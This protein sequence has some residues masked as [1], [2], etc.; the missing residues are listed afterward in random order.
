MVTYIEKE[1]KSILNKHKFID[2]WFWDRYSVNA[3]Q[4]CQFNCTYC[5]A[6]SHKY[7][8]HQEFEEIIVVKKDAAGMLDQRISRARTLLP[9]VV[10]MSGV[11]DP[12]Q[13][14]EEIFGNTRQCLRVLERHHWPVHVITKSPLMLRDKE[15]LEKI[16]NNA[17]A[18]VSFTVTT[19]DPDVAAFLEPRAPS[20]LER[21]EALRQ[22]KEHSNNIQTGILMIPIVP[23]LED[24]E[25]NIES[26]VRKARDAGADY[27]L[28]SPGM[29]MRDNQAIW[30]MKELAR[31]CPDLVRK[32]EQLYNFT[33]SAVSYNGEYTPLK[34]Y[35]SEITK[36]ILPILEKYEMP[37][38]IPR[39][40]PT[41]FRRLNYLVAEKLLEDAFVLQMTGKSWKKVFWA[42]QNIQNLK[43][44][45][46]K[47]EDRSELRSIQSVDEEI[48]AI[49][50]REINNHADGSQKALG[51]FDSTAN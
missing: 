48:E 1:F 6:R 30:F 40:I 24:G 12:Y 45:I 37:F 39:F 23:F 7:H 34:A 41:D 14:A 21:L 29:T 20:S 9:D 4:G 19:L 46:T 15:I 36:T 31:E 51:D 26:T 16:A 2:S 25:E 22:I 50:R 3:Y 44:S 43:E 38:R 32:Y 10:G 47:V 27:V 33:T 5:D 13:P 11:C 8:L 18:T 49:I 42:T 28:F 17:W 35:S